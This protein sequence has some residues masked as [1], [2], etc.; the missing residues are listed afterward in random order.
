MYG[1]KVSARNAT[2]FGREKHAKMREMEAE[3]ASGVEG[4]KQ[5]PLEGG[6]D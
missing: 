5:G 6:R 1:R 3:T 2:E 4:W